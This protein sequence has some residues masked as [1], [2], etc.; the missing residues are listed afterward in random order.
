[1]TF[2]YKYNKR[3]LDLFISIAL[4]LLV[5][6]LIILLI[7]LSS[8]IF[9]ENGLFKQKRVGKNGLFFTIYKIRTL[10][11]GIN[12]KYSNYGVF[13]RKYKLDELPQLINVLIGNM[14]MVGPRPDLLKKEEIS[15][16]AVIKILEMKPGITSL[17]SIK[18]CNEEFLL[19]NQKDPITFYQNKIYPKK[20]ELNEL[21]LKN[22]SLYLDVKILIR[23]LCLLFKTSTIH[24]EK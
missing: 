12:D 11:N 14:S 16:E 20:V 23:T 13:I 22:K 4:L 9:K 6:W 2:L 7:I 5:G 10:K 8:L 1:L 15:S 18:F 24:N 19:E 3:I 21:Y 17:A